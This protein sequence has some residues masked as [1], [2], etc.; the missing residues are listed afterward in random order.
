MIF[1]K[2]RLMFSYFIE[3]KIQFLDGISRR[4]KKYILF[5]EE[6]KKKNV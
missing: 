1:L 5:F 3:E 4:K 2:S 6:D